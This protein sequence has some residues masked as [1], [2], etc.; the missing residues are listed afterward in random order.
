MRR[1]RLSQYKQNK[2]IELFVAGVFK[3]GGFQAVWLIFFLPAAGYFLSVIK[4]W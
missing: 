2:L 3:Q 1:S 4:W